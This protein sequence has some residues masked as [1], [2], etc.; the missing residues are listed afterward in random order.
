MAFNTDISPDRSFTWTTSELD[1]FKLIKNA[2]GGTVNDV[3]LAVAAGALR[4]WLVER[5]V[6][7]DRL[8][9]RPWSRSR[10]GPRTSTASSATG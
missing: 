9:L 10:S 7:V 6:E 2:L 5:D 1:D 3:T 8:E 4:R